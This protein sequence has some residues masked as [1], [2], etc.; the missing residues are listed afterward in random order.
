MT[1]NSSTDNVEGSYDDKTAD[2][3]H[4]DKTA[5]IAH[6]EKTV[7]IA[8]DEKNADIAHDEKNAPLADTTG[9]RQSVALNIIQNPLKVSSAIS[10]PSPCAVIISSIDVNTLTPTAHHPRADRYQC[11]GFC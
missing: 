1:E 9:R 6:D 5:D 10:G 4:D 8:H 3:G 7:D 11:P 2:I